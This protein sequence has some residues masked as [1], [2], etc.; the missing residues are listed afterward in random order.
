M[1]GAIEV[2]MEGGLGN[3]MFQYA[4]GRALAARHSR[5]LVLDTS[6][7]FLYPA[8]TFDLPCFRLGE[9]RV[10]ERPYRL[11]RA[12]RNVLR[13]LDRVGLAPV[14]WV[15][16]SGLQFD[17]DVLQVRPPCV[18][19]GYWQSERYFASVATELREEFAI[20]RAQDPQSAACQ[21]R[22]QQVPSIG[23]HVRRGDYLAPTD[24]HTPCSLPYYEAALRTI[25]PSL[26]P[27]A[28]LF[29]FSDDIAWARE[30]IRFNL[31]TVFVDWNAERNY[32]DLR[33]MSACRALIA[34]NSTFSWWGGWLNP[35]PDKIVVV[36]KDWY[37]SPGMASD[38]P[39]SAWATAI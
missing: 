24:P 28:E 13:G 33:L 19:K 38:L 11:W 5:P 6:L 9:H 17:P 1:R 15:E 14:R 31:P 10:R 34:V 32:E 29:V 7:R 30:H 20:V 37:R 36:P 26:G 27:G 12:R 8:R 4:L 25:T 39:A 22:M 3:A 18:L 23:L 21:A 2:V 16:E 35:R